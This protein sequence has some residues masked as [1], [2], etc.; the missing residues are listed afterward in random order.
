MRIR[1]PDTDDAFAKKQ[2][3]HQ[4]KGI[5]ARLG[6]WAVFV[7]I[8]SLGDEVR[9]RKLTELGGDFLG[10][11]LWGHRWVLSVAGLGLIAATKASGERAGRILNPVIAQGPTH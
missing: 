4:R 1:H 7:K 10:I 11:R 6:Q 8:L 3:F 9:S 2:Q 5:N